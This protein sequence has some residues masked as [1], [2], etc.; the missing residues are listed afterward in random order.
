MMGDLAAIFHWPLDQLL[1][2]PLDQLVKWHGIA[3]DRW[4]AMNPPVKA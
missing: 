1:A 4:K 2:L 3:L